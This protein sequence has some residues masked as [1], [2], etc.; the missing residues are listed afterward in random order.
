MHNVIVIYAG[1]VANTS[2]IN[3][4]N[5]FIKE[6]KGNIYVYAWPSYMNDGIK[7]CLLLLMYEY[8]IIPYNTNKYRYVALNL[9]I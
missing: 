7:K 3:S 1:D 8:I 2:I 5:V 4:I 9:M 6:G